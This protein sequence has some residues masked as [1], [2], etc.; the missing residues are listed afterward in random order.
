MKSIGAM[1]QQL[2]GLLN[3]GDLNSWET[4]FVTNLVL[5]TIHGRDTSMLTERQINRMTELY[6]KHFADAE[7]E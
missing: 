6:R 1:I 7:P 3:T 5:R 2:D 4:Q